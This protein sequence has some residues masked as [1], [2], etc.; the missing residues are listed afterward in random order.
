MW[1]TKGRDVDNFGT[2]VSMPVGTQENSV[3]S[4]R[5]KLLVI[6]DRISTDIMLAKR[7]NG[8]PFPTSGTAPPDQLAGFETIGVLTTT[9]HAKESLGTRILRGIENRILRRLLTSP[10][11]S[12]TSSSA[13]IDYSETLL[14][15][16]SPPPPTPTLQQSLAASINTARQI[17]LEAGEVFK[18]AVNPRLWNPAYWVRD[19]FEQWEERLDASLKSVEERVKMRRTR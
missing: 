3:A 1:N 18:E 13:G 5:R 17:T 2:G 8:L 9:L 12:L 7:I 10:P 16:P 19:L 11:V 15:L 6:G 14:P 4:T